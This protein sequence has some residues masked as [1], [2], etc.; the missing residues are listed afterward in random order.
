MSPDPKTSCG[1]Y[2]SN[3]VNN[4]K[5]QE[6]IHLERSVFDSH[7]HDTIG[8]IVIDKN[9]RISAGTSSNGANHK[10]PGY[11]KFYLKNYTLL[12]LFL[13]FMFCIYS[14][15]VTFSNIKESINVDINLLYLLSP[16]P[17]K[18]YG[19]KNFLSQN[20]NVAKSFARVVQIGRN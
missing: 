4:T 8:M 12:C 2:K 7:N 10:I 3:I 9:N 18:W 1:P 13:F 17:K 19:E 16:P 20:F 14:V 6:S 15:L 11:N 5:E